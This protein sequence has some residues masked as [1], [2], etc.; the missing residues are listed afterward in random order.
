MRETTLGSDV[1]KWRSN[2]SV[3][4]GELSIVDARGYNNQA[5]RTTVV[6]A[7]ETACL[8]RGFSGK[9]KW[10]GTGP[11]LVKAYAYFNDAGQQLGR[12]VGGKSQEDARCDECNFHCEVET[13]LRTLRVHG[14]RSHE[15]VLCRICYLRFGPGPN[16]NSEAFVRSRYGE[17]EDVTD[18]ERAAIAALKQMAKDAV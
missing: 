7:G 15:V 5:G 3:L 13:Y 2:G 11:R 4:S 14:K 1:R 8:A 9:L 10:K 12:C 6:R 17:Q 16:A 18:A